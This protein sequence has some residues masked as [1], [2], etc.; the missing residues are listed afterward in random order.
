MSCALIG[1][2]PISR[3]CR[4][5]FNLTKDLFTVCHSVTSVYFGKWSPMKKYHLSLDL[6]K[7][8]LWCIEINVSQTQNPIPPMLNKYK[9]NSLKQRFPSISGKDLLILLLR[10]VVKPNSTGHA[11]SWATFTLRIFVQNQSILPLINLKSSHNYWLMN[12]K[13]C[14]KLVRDITWNFGCVWLFN[15]NQSNQHYRSILPDVRTNVT[16]RIQV[17]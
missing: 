14:S 5:F 15:K 4:V 16:C 13:I 1:Q 12:L 17:N 8:E 11:S 2:N 7:A 10:N 3:I 9:V 6:C